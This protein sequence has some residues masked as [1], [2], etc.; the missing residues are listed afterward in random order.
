MNKEGRG[1]NEIAN[2][3]NIAQ[4]WKLKSDNGDRTLLGIENRKL[5]L[6]IRRTNQRGEN[7]NAERSKD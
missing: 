5:C 4:N 2:I 1:S 3:A 7:A 6:I